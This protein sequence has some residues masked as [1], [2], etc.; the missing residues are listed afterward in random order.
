[1]GNRQSMVDYKSETVER[2]NSLR[3]TN[4]ALTT[5]LKDEQNAFYKGYAPFS[6]PNAESEKRKNFR[7]YPY[8]YFSGID[9][10][11]FFGDVWVDDIV[12][13]QYSVTQNKTPIYGYASQ[14][15]DAVARGNVIVQGTLTIAF[16]EMGYLNLVQRIVENQG[17]SSEQAL[18]TKVD[19][20]AK[21]NSEKKLQ[22]IPNLEGTPDRTGAT[23]GLG[24][25]QFTPNGSAQIIRQSE[26]IESILVNKKGGN[27]VSSGLST[28]LY[29]EP[30]ND[31]NRDFEDFAEVLE[32]TIWGDSNG[33]PLG[34]KLKYRRADEFDYTYTRSGDDQGGVFVGRDDYAKCLN[35]MMTFGDMNDFRAEHTL[36]VL[37][38]VHF[39][40]QGVL[41]APTGEPI[42]E[43]YSF[44]ARDIN[45]TITSSAV[46]INSLKFDIGGPAPS[47][48]SDIKDL[49]DYMKW[50]DGFA[51]FNVYSVASFKEGS[52]WITTKTLVAQLRNLS[53]NNYESLL[54]QVSRLA[55][56][57]INDPS[58][59]IDISYSQH[60]IEVEMIGRTN[61]AGID[62]KPIRQSTDIPGANA[63]LVGLQESIALQRAADEKRI[64]PPTL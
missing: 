52:E 55:E 20:Y 38:D 60:I 46:K 2:Y 8:D 35:I 53:I 40:S 56:V 43:T 31:G 21:L 30:K 15:Y 33:R 45:Q 23:A 47:V 37:N 57:A 54:D 22:F 27:V 7:T 58:N 16:K 41:L 18:K 28:I 26:T 32:D 9:A 50:N 51:V 59:K 61:Q 42:G 64:P 19:K 36:M 34:K 6:N 24:A 10:K 14:L 17:R 44:F 63:E 12:T 39:T 29:D 25:V 49:E 3:N 11:V 4:S 1:M 48:L 62:N 5:K 13:I